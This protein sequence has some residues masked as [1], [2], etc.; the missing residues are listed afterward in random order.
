MITEPQK[1]WRDLTNQELRW[2]TGGIFS[3]DFQSR[4]A[5]RFLMFYLLISVV[6]LPFWLISPVFAVSA[7][8]SFVTTFFMA[9]FE[10]MLTRQPLLRYWIPLVGYIIV[11][12]IY[13]S[14]LT[15]AAIL[16]PR[17]TW[18]GTSLEGVR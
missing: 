4:F 6:L 10:G 1:N 18:K 9:V 2:H 11:T 15:V 7:A 5:Y 13:N 3:T 14:I 8:V 16:K 17:L 12:M